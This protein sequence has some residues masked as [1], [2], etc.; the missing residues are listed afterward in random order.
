[1]YLEKAWL[2][3]RTRVLTTLGPGAFV[4]YERD[5]ARVLLDKPWAGK[6]RTY[7]EE[8]EIA[9]DTNFTVLKVINVS[10]NFVSS[11]IN[12][13]SMDI[14]SQYF[15]NY[16]FSVCETMIGLDFQNQKIEL[17]QLFNYIGRYRIIET[18]F[19]K[20]SFFEPYLWEEEDFSEAL[21][22]WR[23][24]RNL[25]GVTDGLFLAVFLDLEDQKIL[26]QVLLSTI[27]I[28]KK[29]DYF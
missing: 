6:R 13:P 25:D 16:S 17:N 18:Y 19:N 14:I 11:A 8:S 7:L 26:G 2:K 21:S 15:S 3:P 4:G 9:L 23:Q 22:K 27:K 29:E 28:I 1:M 20:H 24:I 5:A 12:C 10:H